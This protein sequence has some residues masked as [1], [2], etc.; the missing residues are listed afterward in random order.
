MA[1]QD[2]KIFNVRTGERRLD[3]SSVATATG[4]PTL[5]GFEL[6]TYIVGLTTPGPPLPNLQ[7]D[8]T[9]SKASV[10]GIPLAR[11]WHYGW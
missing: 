3:P 4:T 10:H 7:L 8:T 2:P 11:W 1:I 9:Y 5:L 6:A